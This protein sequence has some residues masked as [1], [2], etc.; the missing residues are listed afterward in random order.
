M[1]NKELQRTIDR[2]TAEFDIVYIDSRRDAFRWLVYHHDMKLGDFTSRKSAETAKTQWVLQNLLADLE[3][4]RT[5]VQIR[6]A[7]QNTDTLED[8]LDYITQ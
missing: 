8:A 6:M 1:V 4:N 7:V 2:L 5:V 3:I